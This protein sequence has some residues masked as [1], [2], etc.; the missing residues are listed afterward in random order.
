MYSNQQNKIP[1]KTPQIDQEKVT[2]FWIGDDQPILVGDFN[3]WDFQNG[4]VL[5]QTSDKLWETKLEFPL[6]S[7][8]EYSFVLNGKRALDPFNPRKLSNGTGDINNYF[9]MPSAKPSQ[10]ALRKTRQGTLS[11]FQITDDIRLLDSHRKIFLYQP[12]ANGPYPLVVVYDGLDFLQRGRITNIVDSL[13]QAG[14]IQPIALALVPNARSARF[15]EYAGNDSTV[16]FILNKV[17]PLAQ[18]KL[19]LVD[20][21]K[22]PGAFCVAGASMGGLMALYSALRAPT[23]FGHVI[24]QS[25]AFRMY[26]E[27]FSIFELVDR[28]QIPL[29]KVWMDIGKYDFLYSINQRMHDLLVTKGYDVTYREINGGHNYTTWRNDL[30]LGFEHQFSVDQSLFNK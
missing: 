4:I 8:L 2:F 14:K 3:G 1:D 26:D 11:E 21:E 25:G 18:Q 23:I 7:Y 5:S 24:C 30:A 6:D 10:Y 22:N 19:D 9:Y 20:I 16:S 15:V 29:I 12:D 28:E 27:D 17:I 13:I